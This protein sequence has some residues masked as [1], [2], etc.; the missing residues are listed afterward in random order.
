MGQLDITVKV[1]TIWPAPTTCLSSNK[2]LSGLVFN[3]LARDPEVLDPVVGV[4]VQ[5]DCVASCV[6][7]KK[8]MD[9]KSTFAGN[10]Q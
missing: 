3:N 6:R 1:S 7:T 8:A 5:S 9:S 10:A 4:H 2:M